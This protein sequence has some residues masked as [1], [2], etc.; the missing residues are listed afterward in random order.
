ML[1]KPFKLSSCI[2][3]LFNLFS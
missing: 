1:L 3:I 2:L